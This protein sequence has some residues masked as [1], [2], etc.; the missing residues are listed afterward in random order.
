MVTSSKGRK[1][2]FEL[3]RNQLALVDNAWRQAL[4]WYKQCDIFFELKNNNKELYSFLKKSKIHP[5]KSYIIIGSREQLK[6]VHAFLVFSGA[7][8]ES[9][10]LTS[11]QEIASYKLAD[12]AHRLSNRKN[13]KK[14]NSF[15]EEAEE[16]EKF[17]EAKFESLLLYHSKQGIDTEK[18]GEWLVKC[19]LEEVANRTIDGKRTVILSEKPFYDL[20][21]SGEFEVIRLTTDCAAETVKPKITFNADEFDE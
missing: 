20:E 4:K 17:A 10:N 18:Y 5:E 19:I 7:Y 1:Y 9:N 11:F 2:I 8:L 14:N 16:N 12:Y 13:I 15:A 6:Y 21:T 3:D